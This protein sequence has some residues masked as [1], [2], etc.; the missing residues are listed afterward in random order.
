MN[1]K[2]KLLITLI[3]LGSMGLI[4][5]LAFFVLVA[6]C[7]LL[8]GSFNPPSGMSSA[9]IKLGNFLIVPVGSSV[10]AIVIGMLNL[11]RR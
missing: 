1:L 2:D 4:F 8:A 11:R 9:W 10:T 6:G 7:I 3:A 5:S